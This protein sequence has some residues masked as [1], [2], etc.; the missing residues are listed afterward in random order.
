[1]VLW[2]IEAHA[3]ELN[4]QNLGKNRTQ[5]VNIVLSRREFVYVKIKKKLN[6]NLTSEVIFRL[7]MKKHKKW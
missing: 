7:S 3:A 4:G 2:D 6:F 1:M 5:E